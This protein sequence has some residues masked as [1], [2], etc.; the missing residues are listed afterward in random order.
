MFPSYV[1]LNIL[2][3]SGELPGFF[4]GPIHDVRRVISG[5][6]LYL[7]FL[8]FQGRSGLTVTLI[9]GPN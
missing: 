3:T 8:R 1:E 4:G 5:E 9:L 6:L 2:K 7:V